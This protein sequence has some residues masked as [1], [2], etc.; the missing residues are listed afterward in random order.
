M[1]KRKRKIA[2]TEKES[3]F[4]KEYVN[5]GGNATK[6]VLAAY[7]T[8]SRERASSMGSQILQKPRVQDAIE[9]EL[10]KQNITLSL[11]LKPI[12][13]GL[14]AKKKREDGKMVDDLELQLK[15]SDRAL[16]LLFPTQK[17]ENNLNLNLNIDS[18]HFGGEFVINGEE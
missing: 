5:N 18:A 13:K 2:I 7:D 6:A 11:A 1:P 17:G 3:A 16:K 14:K 4:A 8:T 15:A 9:K 12:A 10:A